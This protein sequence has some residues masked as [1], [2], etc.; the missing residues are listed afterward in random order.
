MSIGSGLGAS[1]GYSAESTY[2]TYVAPARWHAGKQFSIKKVQNFQEVSGVAAGRFA[3]PDD[4]LITEA[5]VGN[6]QGDVLRSKFGLLIA[7]LT[8]STAAPVQQGG[9]AA[10]LQT[11][12]WADNLGKYLT[13]QVGHPSTG[14]TA[15]PKTGLGGKITQAEFS[16]GVDENLALS[17]DL[18]FKQ[19]TE[20]QTLAAPSYTT[21]N[22]PFHFAQ[23]AVKLGTFGSEA[24]VQGVRK[25]GVTIGRGQDTGRFYAGN[26]GLKSEPIYN[27]MGGISGSL[28]VDLVTKADFHDRWTGNTATSLVWE[29]VGPII[30]STFA[31]TFRITLPSVKFKDGIEEVNGADV[32]K[33]SIPFTA[34]QDPTNGFCKIE[35]LSTDT[36]V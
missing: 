6:W 22:L 33:G 2:G 32:N 20:V 24:A 18:D 23:M 25:C 1:F 8:G 31:Y 26:S 15:H 19:Y 11:H 16:C 34:F 13:A 10:Y 12:S 5:A 36:A 17:L 28:D 30:A 14:G 21:P 27:E 35:Y 9:S 4:Q 29:F 3:A 7:H